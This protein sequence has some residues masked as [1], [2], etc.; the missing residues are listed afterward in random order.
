VTDGGGTTV[1][2][3]ELDFVLSAF[4]VAIILTAKFADTELGARY[5]APCA[6]CA[7]I[8][9]QAAPVHPLPLTLQLTPLAAVSLA[10]AAVKLSDCL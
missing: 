4:A 10:T 8:V 6:F 5:V 2:E 9:P 3:A 7:E 1:I